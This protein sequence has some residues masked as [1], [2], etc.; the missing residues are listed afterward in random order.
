MKQI[1]DHLGHR[2]MKSTRIYTK[3]D[4]R[5]LREVAELDVGGLL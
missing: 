1:A 3:I 4:L 5:G 2:S